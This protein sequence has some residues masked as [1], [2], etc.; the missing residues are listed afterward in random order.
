MTSNAIS[1]AQKL[2]TEDNMPVGKLQEKNMGKNYIFAS[3]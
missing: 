1:I 3:S 2:K